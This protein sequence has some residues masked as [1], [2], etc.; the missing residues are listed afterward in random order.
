MMRRIT[1]IDCPMCIDNTES[2]ASFNA[3]EMPSQVWML[4]FVKGKPLTV[5][6]KDNAPVIP[7]PNTELKKAG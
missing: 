5:Q 7:L 4:R 1:G 2:I 6:S 3:V